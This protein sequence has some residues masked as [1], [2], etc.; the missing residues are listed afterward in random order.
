MIDRIAAIAR[1]EFYQIWRDKRSLGLLAFV[2]TF[3]LLLFGFA[4]SLDMRNIRL[5]IV[6][7]SRTRE[8]REFA[9]T[10]LQGDSFAAAGALDSRADVRRAIE[11]NDADVV[12]VIPEDFARHGMRRDVVTV[13]AVVDGSNASLA[14]AAAGYLDAFTQ[15]YNT[16]MQVR[17]LENAG[18][19][20]LVPVDYRPRVWFNPELKSSRY[21]V[22]GLMGYVMIITT[23]ISTALSIVREKERGTIEQILVSPATIAEFMVGKIIPYFVVA[24]VLAVGIVLAGWLLFDVPVRGSIPTLTLA[25]LLFIVGGLGMGMA[26]S[27][28]AQTQEAAFLLATITTALPTQL[29]SGFIFPIEN[30][31]AVL[32]A[33][34]TIVP[35]KYLLIILRG[36]LLK[37]AP[38]EA[39][40]TSLLALAI[41]AA[42][43]MSLAIAR[44]RAARSN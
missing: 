22:P 23:V 32:Q 4:L 33:V 35:A 19:A 13:Q 30:M 25:L 43:T 3:T 12:V 14:A 5:A 24:C 40:W 44:L 42:T 2:P 31:P 20:V 1:K 34:T 6:D 36:I 21:L 18:R 37:G 8:S 29:L 16:R 41:F 26:I 27:T 15:S 17:M 28:L 38:I 9:A 10:L 11:A 7:E 39:Y